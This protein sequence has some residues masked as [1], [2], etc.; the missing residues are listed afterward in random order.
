MMK[1]AAAA[2]AAAILVAPAAASAQ[3]GTYSNVSFSVSQMYDGNLF[4]APAARA[5]RADLITRFGPA[6]EAGVR[7]LPV[8]IDARYELMAER[9][10]DHPELD[11]NL[12]R[13]DAA[14]GLRYLPNER[15]TAMVN[16]Q[17][18]RTHTPG[19][20]NIQ[21]QLSVGRAPAERRAVTSTVSYDW[22][23]ATTLSAGHAF[24]RDDLV[25]GLS[26]TTNSSQLGIRHR[27]SDRAGYRVDYER[28]HVDFDGGA[29]IVSHVITAGRSYAITPRTTFEIAAGPRLTDGHIRPEIV[30]ALG[31]R[32]LWGELLVAFS[33]TELTAIGERG[34]IDV[35]R[36]A[37]TGR[38]RV[39][40]RLV[41]TGTPAYTHNARDD[42]SVP[43]FTLDVESSLEI[44]RRLSLVAWGRIGRQHGTL[45]GPGDV[46]PSQT[47]GIKLSFTPRVAGL[48][49][50]EG[51]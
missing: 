21:S 40:R 51:R 18:I 3:A 31:R 34:A 47:A 43:V 25:G 23:D 1:L 39:T 10:V 45:S 42:R 27:A 5:P 32:A 28:R 14:A 17:F 33:R 4:S 20:L 29:P 36:I 15:F 16:T 24:G 2:S 35:H 50:G 7:S 46:I 13:H 41:L 44:S 12:A 6:L 19:E 8:E 30:A 26:S 48:P 9:Y 37:A 22:S 49:A 11:D 38:Y